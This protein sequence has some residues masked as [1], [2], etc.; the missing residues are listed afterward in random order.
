[1]ISIGTLATETGVSTDALRLY[2]A[3]GLLRAE[4]RANGYRSFDPAAVGVV[5]TIRLAQRLGFTLREI[6]DVT[7]A[8]QD[9]GL[10]AT[11][12]RSLLA[13]KLGEVDERID[14]LTRLRDL[15][16]ARLQDACPVAAAGNAP[17]SPGRRRGR[18]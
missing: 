10:S 18:R 1:M 4:R 6:A 13:A 8:L 11:E 7:D 2:E 9:T 12:V 15:L 17:A 14:A 16:S 5:Q 3:R